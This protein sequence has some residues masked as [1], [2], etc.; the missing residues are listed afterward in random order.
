MCTMTIHENIDMSLQIHNVQREK[1]ICKQKVKT[2]TLKKVS[3]KCDGTS[4][5]QRQRQILKKP[6]VGKRERGTK[7]GQIKNNY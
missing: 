3:N 1:T 2:S 5:R 6:R 7:Q 4:C